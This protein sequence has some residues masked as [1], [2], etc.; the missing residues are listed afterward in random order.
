MNLFHL[1][2]YEPRVHKFMHIY[3][4]YATH[5]VAV[6][7]YAEQA[8]IFDSHTYFILAAVLWTA[9]MGIES[10]HA[11]AQTPKNSR[12]GQLCLSDWRLD[13]ISTH[14]RTPHNE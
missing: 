11:P 6:R 5:N 8:I 4:I 13:L 14:T 10:F 3:K 12:T 2:Y 7:G 1:I 9:W